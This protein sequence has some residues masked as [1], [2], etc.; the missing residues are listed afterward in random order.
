MK[1]FL[2]KYEDGKGYLAYYERIFRPKLLLNTKGFG[3]NVEK[4]VHRKSKTNKN[5]KEQKK[6]RLKEYSNK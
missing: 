5:K 6:L 4:N 1:T 3:K 2:E